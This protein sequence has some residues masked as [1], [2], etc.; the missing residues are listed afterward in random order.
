MDVVLTPLWTLVRESAQARRRF[1]A[2]WDGMGVQRRLEGAEQG[3]ALLLSL[4][5]PPA[6]TLDALVRQDVRTI[7]RLLQTSLPDRDPVPQIAVITHLVDSDPDRTAALRAVI[8]A[9]L[10]IAVQDG[11]MILTLTLTATETALRVQLDTD[12]PGLL[13]LRPQHPWRLRVAQILQHW[14]GAMEPKQQPDQWIVQVTVPFA[15]TEV[16]VCA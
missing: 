7:Q 1:D 5:E 4:I 3:E 16:T 8:L 11:A 15:V 9:L 14:S 6:L 13:G 10:V 2:D 12:R